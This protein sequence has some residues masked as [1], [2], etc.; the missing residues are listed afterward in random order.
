MNLPEATVSPASGPTPADRIGFLRIGVLAVAGALLVPGACVV[1]LSNLEVLAAR[2]ATSASGDLEM[3]RDLPGPSLLVVAILAPAAVLLGVGLLL[4]ALAARTSRRTTMGARTTALVDR[5]AA[6][7]RVG[8]GVLIGLVAV[9]F[10]LPS[11]AA[12]VGYPAVTLTSGSMSPTYPAGSLLFIEQI[13]ADRLAVGDIV[14]IRQPSLEADV[15]HRIIALQRAVD[16]V[17]VQTQGDAAPAPDSEWTSADEV[18]GR[19]VA[20][21]R[22][23]GGLR[24]WLLSPLGLV[25][26]GLLAAV[27]MEG[28]NALEEAGLAGRTRLGESVKPP[29]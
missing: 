5:T 7:L 21:F 22:G 17:R 16:G 18:E 6:L 24:G 8:C 28:I 29:N 4:A 1:M 19:V 11:I 20:G 23:L 14:S 26:F 9:L 2:P 13:P 3:L 27:L 12:V 10:L 25:T 15:M